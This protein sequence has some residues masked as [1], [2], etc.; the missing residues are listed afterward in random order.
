MDVFHLSSFFSFLLFVRW[1]YV[2]GL[3]IFSRTKVKLQTLPSFMEITEEE[4]DINF[5]N[6]RNK[7][8]DHRR[9]LWLTFSLSF[10]V[11][12]E[13]QKGLQRASRLTQKLNLKMSA[14]FL[15]F[16]ADSTA[17]HLIIFKRTTTTMSTVFNRDL[18]F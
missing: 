17:A 10:A 4:M 18:I 6:S 9:R 11:A 1:C 2:S 13:R 8:L 3:G 7:L 16:H 14:L 12:E 5:F 15:Q